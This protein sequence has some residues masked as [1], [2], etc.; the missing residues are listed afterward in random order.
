MK[1][2][3]LLMLG[4][5]LWSTGIFAQWQLVWSDEFNYTGLP[6]PAKWG[7]DVAPPGTW[8]NELQNYT[9]SRLENARVENGNLIIEARYDDYLGYKYSSARVKTMGKGD[10]LYGRVEVMAKLPAGKGSWPAIWMLPTDW[11]Y[12]GWPNSGEIDIMEHVGKDPGVIHASTHCKNYYYVTNNQKTATIEVPDFS[13]A[14]HLYAM[15]WSPSKIDVYVDDVLYFTSLNENTT[16][17]SWPFDQRFHLILNI[18]VGGDWGGRVDTKTLPWQMAVDYVRI[19]EAPQV[20]DNQAP[21]APTSLA[22]TPSSSAVSLTWEPSMD[23]YAIKQYE[24]YNGNQLVGTTIYPSYLVTGLTP[25]TSYTLK[26][27]AVDFSNNSSDYVSV[28]TTTTVVIVHDIPAVIQAEDYDV[29]SGVQTETTTD[30]GS[31]LD[32]GWIDANDYMEYVVGVSATGYFAVDYRA[33]SLSG[34]GQVQLKDL[35]GN[36]LCTTDIPSTGGWQNWTTISSKSFNLP[37]GNNRLRVFASSGGFNLNWLEFKNSVYDVAPP[38]SPTSLS[39]IPSRT[40]T[41]LSWS[42]STDNIA[43]TGYKAYLNGIYVATTTALSYKFTGLTTKTGYTLGVSAIDGAG[44]ESSISTLSV[45]TKTTDDYIEDK[46]VFEDFSF[47]PNPASRKIIVTAPD[48]IVFVTILD[49]T[50]RQ[51]LS[52]NNINTNTI[53]IDINQLLNGMYVVKLETADGT[54]WSK[55]LLKK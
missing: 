53:N 47:Y 15:D 49:L 54:I 8:N 21:P 13:T 3:L 11:V 29:M 26:V 51:V 20:A 17:A 12:G 4:M 34:G 30:V 10:W 9:D 44:N 2:N 37:Q 22:A 16:W 33:A 28:S 32:V 45:T 19:Y 38:S 48:D 39:A 5:F 24:I 36:V 1:K 43:V 23:N 25:E 31:G 40:F 41:T 6:D 7:Y 35:N 18:A 42:A 50:G 46:P 52:L 27:R 55:L 14:Y